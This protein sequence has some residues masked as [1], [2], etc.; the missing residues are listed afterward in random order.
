MHIGT[1]VLA[2]NYLY[3]QYVLTQ[4]TRLKFLELY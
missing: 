1:H 2:T 4:F 3:V